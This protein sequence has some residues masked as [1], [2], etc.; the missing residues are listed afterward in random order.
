MTLICVFSFN[1]RDVERMQGTNLRAATQFVRGR[2]GHC[3]CFV[4]P[5]K[6]RT[7]DIMGV[8]SRESGTGIQGVYTI[9]RK[10]SNP[11]MHQW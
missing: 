8:L 6:R 9:C 1:F 4:F 2:C 3:V 7:W 5:D 11:A 10:E